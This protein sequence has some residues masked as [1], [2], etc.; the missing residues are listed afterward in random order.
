[1]RT[2]NRMTKE[3]ATNLGIE[4][5]WLYFRTIN[6][7]PNLEPPAD[8]S[9][10]YKL[11]SVGLWNGPMGTEGDSIGVVTKW[12]PPEALDGVSAA[13]FMKV[14]TVIRGGKWRFDPQA[15]DWVGKAVAQALKLPDPASDKPTKGKIRRMLGAWYKAKSLVAVDGFDAKRKPKVFVEVADED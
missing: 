6:G 1:M 8:K 4:N 7:K 13:D 9:E 15:K 5:P 11:V 2:I 14:A 10:W 12:D 3:Q